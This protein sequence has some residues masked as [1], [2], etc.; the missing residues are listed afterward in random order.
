MSDDRPDKSALDELMKEVPASSITAPKISEEIII[1]RP[2]VNAVNHDIWAGRSNRLLNDYK[3]G[4]GLA[5]YGENDLTT[6][7]FF[8]RF[9]NAISSAVSNEYQKRGIGSEDLKSHYAILDS[10][11]QLLAKEIDKKELKDFEI[12]AIIASL[13]GFITNYNQP[14]EIK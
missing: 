10:C 4:E 9:S 12:L 2:N 6:R 3:Y 13:Q 8:K 7:A 5:K 11:F 1:R 14:K